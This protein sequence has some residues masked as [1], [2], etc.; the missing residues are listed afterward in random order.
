VQKNLRSPEIVRKT[1][2]LLKDIGLR[3]H[4]EA[5]AVLLL[6]IHRHG[7][8]KEIYYS[9]QDYSPIIKDR[10]HSE[11]EHLGLRDVVTS[12]SLDSANSDMICKAVRRLNDLP[13]GD[14][15]YFDAIDTCLMAH[16][17][18]TGMSPAI[19]DIILRIASPQGRVLVPFCRTGMLCARTRS[20][21]PNIHPLLWTTLHDRN[22]LLCRMAMRAYGVSHD[23]R[24]VETSG[25]A[26]EEEEEEEILL[27]EGIDRT[28]VIV[29]DCASSKEIAQKFNAATFQKLQDILTPRGTLTLLVAPGITSG[30]QFKQ[31]RKK[32]VDNQWLDA[33]IRLPNELFPRIRNDIYLIVIRKEKT[34]PYVL[35]VD[36]KEL[37]EKYKKKNLIEDTFFSGIIDDYWQHQ[38]EGRR[39]NTLESCEEKKIGPFAREILYSTIFKN[40]CDF[41]IVRYIAPEPEV[42]D[43]F[44]ESED[45]RNIC[46]KREMAEKELDDCIKR[47][48]AQDRRK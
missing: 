10:I 19:A 18:N 37:S 44:K 11:A 6:Y 14:R 22:A 32:L 47:V 5:F 17:Q 30:A 42:I 45:L 21:A 46:M 12:I 28:D 2:H 26:E 38:Y 36:G 1:L 43:L 9:A 48:L 4:V 33:I 27:P 40:N 25:G 20:F 34:G 41:D 31:I 13:S 7:E 3:D 23:T 15:E 35:F 24:V 8:W 29:A 39:R 16:D